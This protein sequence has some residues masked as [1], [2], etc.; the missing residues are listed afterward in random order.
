MRSFLSR[1][2]TRADPRLELGSNLRTPRPER[3]FAVADRRCRIDSTNQSG[4]AGRAGGSN[5]SVTCPNAAWRKLLR[6]ARR[7]PF[8]TALGP[9]TCSSHRPCRSSLLS[10]P[11]VLAFLAVFVACREGDPGGGGDALG[12]SFPLGRNVFGAAAS[13]DTRPDP[14][15]RSSFGPGRCSHRSRSTRAGSWSATSTSYCSG[16]HPGAQGLPHSGAPPC[17]PRAD[18]ARPPAAVR[19]PGC[20]DTL[21]RDEEV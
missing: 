10:P 15:S 7:R 5:R 1:G 19:A 16:S 8:E 20:G 2:R 13:P 3:R 9:T 18:A 17:R 21:R 11:L 14:A 12:G 6:C 4:R